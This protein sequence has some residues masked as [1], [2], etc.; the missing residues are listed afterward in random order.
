[1][2]VPLSPSSSGLEMLLE[3]SGHTLTH[4]V[5]NIIL[6]HNIFSIET[7]FDLVDHVFPPSIYKVNTQ[8]K[9]VVGPSE[10][11]AYVGVV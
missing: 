1:M 3:V 9:T 10:T 4:T 8:T 6:V 11:L 7:A 2:I 5:H